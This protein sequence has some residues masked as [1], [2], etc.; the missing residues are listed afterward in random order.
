MDNQRLF[1]YGALGLLIL[2]IW[3]TWQ[4]DY[5][6]GSAAPGGAQPAAEAPADGNQSAPQP[7]DTP[8]VPV[9]DSGA[10]G[11]A[12]D[13]SSPETAPEASPQ[14]P[15]GE[16]VH[17]VTDL[18]DV[19]LDTRGGDM[20]DALLRT[21]ESDKKPGQPVQLLS[22]EPGRM[23]IAQSGLQA[24]DAPA[25]THHSAYSAERDE[26]RLSEGQDTLS[27]PLT[28]TG[29]GIRVTKTYTFHRDSYVVDVAFRV[30]NRGS[31]EWVGRTY[32]QLQREKLAEGEKP[33]LLPTFFG[34]AYYSDTD[35]Y[36]K[37]GFD[38][39]VE[40]P[41]QK[42]V[43]G[44][45]AA[46]VEH[47]F[48]AA[49]IPDA[50]D[51]NTIY[52]KALDPDT[53]NVRYIIGSYSPAQRVAAGDTATF[54]TRL[55]VGPKENGQLEGTAKGL[56][57]T[58]DYGYMSFLSAP[59]FWVL[60]Y[61]HSAVGNWGWSIVLLTLMIKLLFY[62]LSETSY[63][64]MARMKKMQPKIQQLKERY[65]DD[66]EKMGRAMMDLYKKEKINPLGGCLPIVVQIPVFIAL[67]WMLLGSVELRHADWILWINDL[68]ARDP[69]YML[70]LLMGISMWTQQKLNPAPVDPIQQKIFMALPFVF[71]VFF[72]FFPAGLVLY[73]LTNNVLSITQQYYITRYV[74]GDQRRPQKAG[75]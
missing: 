40:D 31:S 24:S 17:V 46:M 7:Q 75:S 74:V 11:G 60:D 29:D 47:Y 8:D 14:L 37:L 69:Y 43:E 65:G 57:L 22:D 18:L 61:I 27:V 20:R 68:S 56:E 73:W 44:G 12:A 2:V 26:Y 30:D 42:Q 72:S 48:L 19:T 36:E 62:K 41:I 10:Q 15:R 32:R 21:Y 33:A 16:R 39:I 58:I 3:Q 45:W 13:Q 55:Y 34:A 1:L 70:P 6:S 23:F 66:R 4:V 51:A 52:T 49:W 35:K 5:G 67:Y 28:W 59:L 63:K 71:T 64:S 53:P 25:P 54:D 9:A 38:D 50:K